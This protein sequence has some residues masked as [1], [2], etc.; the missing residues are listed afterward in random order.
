MKKHCSMKMLE[1][2][3]NASEVCP[4]FQIDEFKFVDDM[5]EED[6]C[7]LARSVAKHL[8]QKII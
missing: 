2:H 3:R 1:D 4:L 5:T 6:V 7:I 8:D